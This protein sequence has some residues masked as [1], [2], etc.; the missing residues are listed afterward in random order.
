MEM[1]VLHRVPVDMRFRRGDQI[2]DRKG[3]PN[4]I[5]GKVEPSDKLPD[6]GDGGMAMVVMCL[7]GTL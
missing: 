1:N 2:V 3:V 5:R 6:L 7:T 4:H